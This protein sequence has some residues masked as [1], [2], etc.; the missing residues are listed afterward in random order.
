METRTLISLFDY[1]GI[2]SQ[3]Y[4]KAGWDVI[5]VDIKHGVD[6]WDFAHRVINT[7]C[8]DTSFR[9]NGILAATPCTHV[10]G[11]GAHK[12]EEKDA[13]PS[14]YDG[15]WPIPVDSI[16]DEAVCLFSVT[17]LII[18]R[19][20]PTDF[21][22]LENPVGR[23]NKLIPEMKQFGPWYF[24]PSDYGDPYTKKTGLW[25]VF[26]KPHPSPVLP[27]F[28]SEMRDKYSS[29][30]EKKHGLRSATPKGFAQAFYEANN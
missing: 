18:E 15:I 20:N 25:G 13:T 28:G 30:D 9:V 1:T 17:R 8:D 7:T 26:N 22:A 5:R 27:L 24:Q 16:T 14:Y 21:W 23:L 12:W 29:R 11:S 6:I 19:L 2:W 3:P 10:S 4:K